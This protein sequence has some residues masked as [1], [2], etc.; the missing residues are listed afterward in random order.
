VVGSAISDTTTGRTRLLNAVIEHL[1]TQGLGDTSLRGLAEAVGTSHRMLIYHFHTKGR[2][3]TAVVQAVEERQR[4]VL[5]DLAADSQADL[6][7]LARAFWQRLTD[8]QL[9]GLERLFFELYGQALRGSP[10]AQ[11]LLPQAIDSWLVPL[12]ELLR[13]RGGIPEELAAARA[14]LALAQTRG[15][16]LDLLATGQR[17]AVDAAYEIGLRALLEPAAPA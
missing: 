14:R 2:L 17:E 1:A 10:W 15:L 12:T 11:G 5:A 16:L 7:E 6:A 3:L 4:A 9:A 8:P 13:Q